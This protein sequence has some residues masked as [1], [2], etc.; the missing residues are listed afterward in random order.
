MKFDLTNLSADQIDSAKLQLYADIIQ[1]SEPQ[2]I[3]VFL[4][5]GSAWDES[6]ITYENMPSFSDLITSTTLDSV[7]YYQWELGDIIK[8]NASKHLSLMISFVTLLQNTEDIVV[9]ASKESAFDYHPTLIISIIVEPSENVVHVIPTDDT[10]IGLDFNTPDDF[11]DLRNSNYGNNDFIKIWYSNNAT[12]AQEL[13]TTSGLLTFDLS[14]I[15]VDDISSVNLK[16]KTVHVASSGADKTLSIVKL[17]NTS[18]SESELTFTNHPPFEID[19]LFL[20][21]IT[22]PN[23]WYTWDITSTVKENTD[24]K[25]SLSIS[26]D[27]TYSG[28]EEQ[29]VFY[30]KESQF[31]PYLEITLKEQGGGCLIATATYGSEM[32]TQVQQLREL[33]DNSLLQTE[34]GRSFMASFNSIYYS[35]SPGIADLERQSLIFKE[36]V[37]LAIT[38]LVSSLSLLNHVDMDSETKVLGYGISIIL[39]NVGMYF[40]APTMLFWSIKNHIKKN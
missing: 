4:V 27:R 25:L 16:I 8:Q 6:T 33:R 11:Y 34:T 22:Q 13:I 24:S 17:N 14:E 2:D 20:A 26:Y 37:K 39:L 3:G 12:S 7:N 28:H 35:F 19:N 40:V 38:P 15:N 29:I 23:M 9:F 21:E 18:W 5:N 1:L 31:S 30:S 36:I 32:A 10:F